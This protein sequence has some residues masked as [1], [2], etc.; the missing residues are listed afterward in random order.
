M[1][2]LIIGAALGGLFLAGCSRAHVNI[3]EHSLTRVE[4]N[5]KS[6]LDTV[7]LP[8]YKV[9]VQDSQGIERYFDFVYRWYVAVGGNNFNESSAYEQ[10]GVGQMNHSKVVGD[11]WRKYLYNVLY[12]ALFADVAPRDPA[13]YQ[14][15][16]NLIGEYGL[17]TNGMKDGKFIFKP[18]IYTNLSREDVDNHI[19]RQV[20]PP[21][22]FVTSTMTEVTVGEESLSAGV[23][24]AGVGPSAKVVRTS[25]SG[26]LEITDPYTGELLVSVMCQ[27]QVSAYQIGAEAFR[28][29]SAFGI[30]DEFMNLGYTEAKE[31]IKQQVQIEL[32]EF[33]AA[34]AFKELHQKKPEYL[35]KRLHNKVGIIAKRAKE[36]AAAEGL[37]IIGEVTPV[38]FGK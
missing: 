22:L 15:I 2:I 9:K 19:L 7:S 5:A 25:I 11:G 35:T 8:R 18:S 34:S 36:L 32:A 13:D 14:A 31:M 30:S 20:I 23:V 4:D 24:I 6:S 3:K 12:R 21:E 28:I 29:V 33:L 38:G 10:A 26:T 16:R 17:Q 1:R 37:T 27:N